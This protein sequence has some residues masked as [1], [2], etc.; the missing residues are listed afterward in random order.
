MAQRLLDKLKASKGWSVTERY[1]YDIEDS[2]G[3]L[4]QKVW[5]KP[6]SRAESLKVRE[7]GEP[8]DLSLR[9][10]CQSVYLEKTGSQKAFDFAEISIMK[11]EL[12]TTALNK[13]EMAV[14]NAGQPSD[15]FIAEEK[16]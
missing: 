7:S 16:K 8:D 9:L 13:L 2:S 15:E 5:I 4:I 3:N 12:S 6:L 1:P 11:R 14:L 10:V